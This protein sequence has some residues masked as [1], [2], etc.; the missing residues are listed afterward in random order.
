MIARKVKF[1]HISKKNKTIREMDLKKTIKRT[2]IRT[3]ITSIIILLIL[4]VKIS[5]YET[6]KDILNIVQQNMEY[7]PHINT[8]YSKARGLFSNLKLLGKNVITAVNLKSETQEKFAMPI[9]KEVSIYFNENIDGSSNRSNGLVFSS[10]YRENI[11]AISQGV[12]IEVGGNKAIGEYVII[13]HKGELLSVYKYLDEVNIVQNQRIEKG[14]IIG[15]TTDKLLLE[16]WKENK[17][18]DPLK[19][20]DSS[21]NQ[22]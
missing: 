3:V 18:V 14:E 12:I 4:L 6:P 8:Y 2:F 21:M 1:N 13:K 20:I 7:S 11:A 22:L 10:N 15:K 17:P 19:H 9:N 16:I 5:K